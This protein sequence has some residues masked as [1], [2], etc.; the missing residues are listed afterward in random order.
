MVPQE[1][2]YGVAKWQGC[3]RQGQYSLYLDQRDGK[4]IGKIRHA[5]INQQ[6]PQELY[7]CKMEGTQLIGKWKSDGV[8]QNGKVT[9]TRSGTFMM[10]LVGNNRL[11]GTATEDKDGIFKKGK[12]WPWRWEREAKEDRCKEA[13]EA[14]R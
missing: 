14:L 9:G 10:T 4:L 2:A 8:Y 1:G 13:K 12:Q 7:D 6:D 11:E 5:E 3:W